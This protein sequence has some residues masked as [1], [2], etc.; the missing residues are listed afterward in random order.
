[1]RTVDEVKEKRARG[2]ELRQ[3]DTPRCGREGTGRRNL[4]ATFSFTRIGGR[5]SQLDSA[6][7]GTETER[8]N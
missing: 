1:V 8:E 6:P 7:G 5:G 4:R 3:A 2:R